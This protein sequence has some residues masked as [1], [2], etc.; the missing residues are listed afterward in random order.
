MDDELNILLIN[1]M[2][3]KL[4]VLR[5]HQIE[6]LLSEAKLNLQSIQVTLVGNR[7]ARHGISEPTD[8]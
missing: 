8:E 4:S 5:F 6:D 7:N 1:K 3:K 2:C